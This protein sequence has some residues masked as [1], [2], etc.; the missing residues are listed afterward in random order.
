MRLLYDDE[1]P[2]FYLQFIPHGLCPGQS[3]LSNFRLR[4]ISHWNRSGHHQCCYSI[5]QI[6]VYLQCNLDFFFVQKRTLQYKID[7]LFIFSSTIAR[8]LDGKLSRG[9]VMMLI[10][11]IWVYVLPWGLMPLMGV[12]GKYAPEGFLTTCT[13]DYITDT[14]EVRYFVATIFTFSYAIPMSLIIYFYSQIVGHVVNHEKALR[15]QAKKMNVESLR[16]NANT[17]AQSAEV[18]IA[19]VSS[20]NMIS[21]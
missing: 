11:L 10:V 12:W 2:H 5:R 19:K 8:P 18:R 20:L 13:F 3:W 6:Q 17:Q 15:E 21:L 1:D 14:D 4:W 7:F 9:Q 16:S